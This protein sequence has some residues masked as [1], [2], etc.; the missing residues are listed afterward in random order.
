MVEIAAE[1]GD[2]D[3]QRNL[4]LLYEEGKGVRQD[5]QTAKKWYEKAAKQKNGGAQFLLGNLYE[6][7]NGVR[8]NYAQAKEYFGQACDNGLQIGCDKYAELNKKGY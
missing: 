2:S 4:G 7:G 5:Y 3:A 1:L 6:N 8:Q